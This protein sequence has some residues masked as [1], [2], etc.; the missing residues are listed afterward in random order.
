MA[1]STTEHGKSHTTPCTSSRLTDTVR[2]VQQERLLAKRVLHFGKTQLLWECSG[3][4]AA[5]MFPIGL[6]GMFTSGFST[7]KVNNPDKA[8]QDPD[9]DAD[10]KSVERD[11]AHFNWQHLSTIHD[12]DETDLERY[13]VHR[14][15]QNV[16]RMYTQCAMTDPQDKLIAVAGIAKRFASYIPG[17]YVAGLWRE[18][19]EA[20]LFWVVRDCTESTR[21]SVYRAPSWSWA[22][23]DAAC[24]FGDTATSYRG[25]RLN[26]INVTLQH[27]DD[28]FGLV[29][30]A[31]LTLE[32]GLRRVA[33]Q[34]KSLA[35]SNTWQL[36]I[37]GNTLCFENVA[38][39][40]EEDSSGGVLKLDIPQHNLD[41][42]SAAGDLF[43][44]EG[45]VPLDEQSDV[46]YLLLK[47]EDAAAGVFSRI[48]L[49][50]ADWDDYFGGST[51]EW[52]VSVEAGSNLPC[53]R[54]D[55]DKG[56]HTICL[57]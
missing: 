49:M 43:A 3:L 23:V 35:G 20:H 10:G 1:G 12:F 29:K 15:W 22:S 5:E 36:T 46:L 21:P 57:I 31:R 53:V 14:L 42:A 48:G 54:W 56:L 26:I 41:E 16:L 7:F 27:T 8:L 51:D 18:Y 37:Q 44:M 52:S 19:F 33:V 2:R 40:D 17:D 9:E 13:W 32:G 47:V 28:V 55:P 30:E 25:S 11:S 50:Y 39:E 24:E 6:P 45:V 38:I 4:N 34:S